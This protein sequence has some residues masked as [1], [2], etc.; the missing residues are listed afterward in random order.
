LSQEYSGV[1]QPVRLNISVT[2]GRGA[3]IPQQLNIDGI[4]ARFIGKSEQMQWQMKGG[5]VNSTATSTFSYLIVPLRPGDFTIPP[6]PVTI[7]GK[8]V[9]TVPLTLHVMGGQGVPVRPAIPVPKSQT[10]RQSV[11]P[12]SSAQTP[13]R[14][15][16]SQSEERKITFGDLIIPKK[17]LYVGEVVPVEL[18]FYFDASYPARL[19]DR[20]IFAGEGF[21]VMPFSKPN[22]K[23]QEVDGR[24][25]NVV[26]FQTAISAAKA[27]TLEVAPATIESQV[28]VPSRSPSGFDDF[29]GGF[30]GNM[31]SGDIRQITVRT[32]SA[33]LEVKP[34]PKDGRPED[35]SGAV[36]QFSLQATAAPKQAAAGDPIS[37][38][39]AVSGRGN[40]DAMAPPVLLNAEGWRSYPPGEKFEASPSDPVGF[41]GEKRF[42]FMI[43][44][45]EDQ[46]KTPVAQ[47]SFFDPSLEKYV[48]IKS[49][50]IEVT[51]KGTADPAAVAAATPAAQPAP[52][53]S[54]VAIQQES[55]LA[56]DFSPASFTP[57]AHGRSFLVANGAL[58]VVWS[59]ALMFGLGRAAAA[60]SL[61]KKS[62]ARRESRKLFRRMQD[63]DCAPEQFLDMAG[64]F[65][66]DRLKSNGA[67]SDVSELLENSRAS[68]ETKLAMR[69]VLSR[70]DEGRYSANGAKLD[71]AERKQILDQL[72]TF[73]HEIPN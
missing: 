21:T 53:A 15:Q 20:P 48:T 22:E 13:P 64:E 54:P 4:D 66:C 29:F 70:R 19:P 32:Q 58:A 3:Q 72:K 43:V 24:V 63:P 71:A 9:K 37:F 39:V 56:S 10:G 17:T 34:L 42:E 62:A 31:M 67:P 50:A 30:F 49:T 18:R 47:L 73:D 51:A 28:Q 14:S 35:F 55:L 65:I 16:G 6:I 8:T 23:Q 40:F 60:S 69:T 11:S 46:A 25:Y 5:G 33:K 26:I 7:G 41:I 38:N 45:R 2:G 52:A 27:G 68:D 12:P 59:V 61:A 44:A 57:F 36:G 1:G